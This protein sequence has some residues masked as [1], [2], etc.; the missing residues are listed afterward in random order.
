MPI[1]ILFHLFLASAGYFD[2]PIIR[3]LLCLENP[4]TNLATEIMS[5][6]GVV[7]GTYF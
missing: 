2:S 6:D 5:S 1:I 3:C 7:L 4:P